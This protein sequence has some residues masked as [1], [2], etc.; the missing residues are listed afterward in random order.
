MERLVPLLL[1]PP[2]FYFI[3]LQKESFLLE[4][5]E[6]YPKQTMRNRFFILTTQ[7]EKRISI[8]IKKNSHLKTVDIEI[9]YAQAWLKTMKTSLETCYNSAPFF[10]FYR[11]DLWIIFESKPK[12]LVDLNLSLLEWCIKQLQLELNLKFTSQF[13][14]ACQQILWE[15]NEIDYPK[16]FAGKNLAKL[17]VLDLIFN[18]GPESFSYVSDF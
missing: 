6:T 9:D 14:G 13:M 3:Y 11:D 2:P 12:Y 18:V 15:K 5:H 4:V 8:P 17:S 10:L 1:L 16:V 7:G